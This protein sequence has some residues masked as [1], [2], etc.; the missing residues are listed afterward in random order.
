MSP[1]TA[2]VASLDI[3]STEDALG[4][5]EPEDALD[6]M[7]LKEP[8]A[9]AAPKKSRSSASALQAAIG[10]AMRRAIGSLACMAPHSQRRQSSMSS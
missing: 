1:V 10:M 4:L 9:K 5:Q 3:A 8:P 7:A 2:K 6:L